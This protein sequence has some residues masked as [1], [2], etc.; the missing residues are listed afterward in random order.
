MAEFQ[1]A[2]PTPTQPSEAPPAGTPAKQYEFSPQE[3]EVLAELAENCSFGGWFM[4]FA[5]VA[6][7]AVLLG[8]WYLKDV[9]MYDGPFRFSYVFWPL[10]VLILSCSFIAAGKAFQKV[11]DTQG[12]DISHLMTG[13]KELNGAFGLLNIFPRIWILIAAIG[14]IVGLVIAT[15]HV[16]GY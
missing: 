7:H 15:M 14:G 2:Q 13:L 8:R 5:L 12:S 4:I 6:Y 9:P 1:S 11:V 10:M 3:N 16:L